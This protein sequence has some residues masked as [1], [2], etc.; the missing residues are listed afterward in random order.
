MRPARLVPEG[1][2]HVDPLRYVRQLEPFTAL[3]DAAFDPVAR[4]LEVVY[5]PAGEQLLTRGGAPSS[6]LMIVRKGAVLLQRDAA[7][8]MT[9]EQG[10]WFGFPSLLAD[11]PPRYDAVA[12]EDVLLYRIPA[13]VVR[14]LVRHPS[15]AAH[16]TR[17]LA[18]RLRS[19]S[20]SIGTAGPASDLSTPVGTLVKR[21]PVAVTPETTVGEAARRMRQAR[22]SAVLVAG[23]PMGIVT[24]RDLRNRVLAVGRGPDTLVGEI[25]SVPVRLVAEDTPVAEALVEMLDHGIHHLAVARDGTVVGMFTSGDA[26]RHQSQSPLHLVRRIERA[27]EPGDLAGVVDGLHG[28]VR[29]MVR[30]GLAPLQV[31]RAATSISD[32]L[33]RHLLCMAER[34]LGPPPAPY[35]WLALGS[36]ARREQT[37]VTDQDS[38]LVHGD[39]DAEGRQWFAAFA[40]R[41]VE[42]LVK[43]GVPPCPGGTMATRWTGTLA[44]W[45]TR[46]ERWVGVPDQRALLEASIF[47]DLRVLH[48][49]LD[50]RALD[51]VLVRAAGDGVF[52]ARLAAAALAG[53]PPLGLFHRIRESASGTVDLKA[54]GILPVVDLARLL[55]VEAGMRARATVERLRG[56]VEAGGISPD[57]SETLVEAFSFLLQLR[58]DAQLDALA[59][60]AT[61]GNAVDPDLLTPTA[62]RHL[63]E[64]F[65]AIEEIQRVTVDRL[66]GFGV[67]R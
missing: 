9:V 5:V 16:I 57:G 41:V 1:G 50:V 10:E 40:T 36:Q 27:D 65:V 48:G 51:E 64:A 13:P 61:P 12:A 29:T 19:S 45:Q 7:T 46:F 63:K 67:S 31:A 11:E 47:F 39:V 35:A 43:A 20:A 42:G 55:A 22:I 32:T 38:A 2:G 8:I 24:D 59:V 4:T 52:L 18:E 58:L 30:G 26:L 17:G 49:D 21:E 23:E 28:V 53:R 56:G 6:Y 60:G 66:G 34:D 54:G 15:V 14:E 62:R 37:L 44:E 33:A 3:D 25:A